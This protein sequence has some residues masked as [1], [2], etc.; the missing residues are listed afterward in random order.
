MNLKPKVAVITSTYKRPLD[1]VDRCIRSV[2]WQTYGIENIVHYICHDG[3]SENLLEHQEWNNVIYTE[4]PYNTNSYGAGVRQY[5]LDHYIKSRADIDYVVHLDDDNLLFPDFIE[6][7]VSILESNLE[8]HFSICKI[9]HLGPLPGH[10]GKPPQILN[11][12]PPVFQNIDTLQVMVRVPSMI[13]CGWTQHQGKAGYCND[14]YTYDRLGKLF[15]WVEL[16][17]LLAIHL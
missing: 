5:V 3:P 16:P 4:V 9:L 15:K 2:Q 1:I 11:G 13:A 17:K 10:L 12:T 7:H 8:A 14:G 6:S